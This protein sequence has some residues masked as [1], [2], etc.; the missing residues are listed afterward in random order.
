ML[1][2]LAERMKGSAGQ[3][4]LD[5]GTSGKEETIYMIVKEGLSL[6]LYEIQ[7]AILIEH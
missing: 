2:C 1:L 5:F 3:G 7:S 6:V 4:D